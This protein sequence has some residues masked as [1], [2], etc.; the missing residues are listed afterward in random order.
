M[1]SKTIPVKLV[2]LPIPIPIPD[3]TEWL[4]KNTPPEY[5]AS[6][7]YLIEL[8]LNFYKALNSLITAKLEKLEEVRKEVEKKPRKEKVKVE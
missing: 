8:K 3:F 7:S 2:Y 4:I 1:E 5:R 6:L